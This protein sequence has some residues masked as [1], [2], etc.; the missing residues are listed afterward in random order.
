M[1]LKL[2]Q[3]NTP[4]Y[5]AYKYLN[6]DNASLCQVFADAITND[7]CIDYAGI[8]FGIIGD[9]IMEHN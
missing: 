3:S 6:F 4:G 1:R 9:G 5:V 7:S 8:F 2:H